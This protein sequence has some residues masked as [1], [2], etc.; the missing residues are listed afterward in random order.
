M[1]EVDNI[2]YN[3]LF[4]GKLVDCS[5]LKLHIE[6]HLIY[7]LYRCGECD[8]ECYEDIEFLDHIS[9]TC[10]L[11]SQMNNAYVKLFVDRL[12]KITHYAHTE[13]VNFSNQSFKILRNNRNG[14]K[15]KLISITTLISC[16]FCKEKL[17]CTDLLSHISLHLNFVKLDE[18]F[19]KQID[20]DNVYTNLH[21]NVVVKCIS[22]MVEDDFM[23]ATRYGLEVL[24]QNDS[25]IDYFSI[26][27]NIPKENDLSVDKV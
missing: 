25:E 24:L 16:L 12:Q 17:K 9:E 6:S 26:P 19:R 21:H 10:H 13:K 27:I 2:K 23:F 15:Y 3:C 18:K 8:F 22:R 4:C 1:L 20:S 11:S 7:P 14:I 5:I